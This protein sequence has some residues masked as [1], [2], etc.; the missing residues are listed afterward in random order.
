MHRGEGNAEDKFAL[1][2]QQPPPGSSGQIWILGGGYLTREHLHFLGWGGGGAGK[3]SW[4][5]EG[6]FVYAHGDFP[7]K[8]LLIA[9]YNA[10]TER[11][12]GSTFKRQCLLLAY[13][14]RRK[15]K[16]F[17]RTQ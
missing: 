16:I 14:E 15:V 12:G 8:V 17:L 3:K 13:S 6:R 11:E 5:L 7:F 9:D 4:S 2:S 1:N 10:Y